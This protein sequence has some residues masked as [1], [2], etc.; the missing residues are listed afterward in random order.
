LEKDRV[1]PQNKNRNKQ[2]NTKTNKGANQQ[3]QLA[4]RHHPQFFGENFGGKKLWRKGCCKGLV[5]KIQM[6]TCIADHQ[7]TVK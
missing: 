7:L 3:L 2:T 6:L 1:T 5:K 4:K